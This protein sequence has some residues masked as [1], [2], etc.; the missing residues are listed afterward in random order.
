MKG[1]EGLLGRGEPEEQLMWGKVIAINEWQWR[2]TEESAVL[3]LFHLQSNRQ[4]R[5]IRG[6]LSQGESNREMDRDIE[7]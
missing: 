2:N 6:R 5:Y 7:R 1:R 4:H 3:S